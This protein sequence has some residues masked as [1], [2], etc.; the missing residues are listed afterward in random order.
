M[1]CVYVNVYTYNIIIIELFLIDIHCEHAINYKHTIILL[2]VIMIIMLII[3]YHQTQTDVLAYFRYFEHI[4]LH[5]N[6]IVD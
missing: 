1:M 2:L 3:L 5:Y 6:I 4:Q